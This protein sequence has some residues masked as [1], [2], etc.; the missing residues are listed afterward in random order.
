MSAFFLYS[1]NM[2]TPLLFALSVF[3]AVASGISLQVWMGFLLLPFLL[4]RRW[5]VLLLLAGFLLGLWRVQVYE[6]QMIPAPVNAFVEISGEIVEEIDKRQDH[7]KITVLTEYGRVLVKLSQYKEFE[8]G[9][10]VELKG[11]LERPSDDIEGFDYAAY[12]ARYRVWLTMNRASVTVLEKAEP[13]IRGALYEFKGWMEN[14]L[15]VLYMEP[16]ASFAAGLLLG[17]RKGMPEELAMAFQ[18]V[19]LTHIVAISG[20][21][22]SLVIAGMFLF[23]SFLPLKQRVVVS[24][25]AII[26]FVILVGASAAVVRAGIMGGLTLWAL[27]SG[28]KSQVFFALLWSALIMVMMNPYILL[29]DAGFQLSFASTMG[30]L[31]FVPMLEKLMPRSEKM[32]VLREAFLLT[33]AA[34]IATVPLILLHFGRLSWISPIAN[35]L[36]APFLAPA[37]FFGALSLV[38]GQPM[39]MMAW[40]NLRAVELIAIWIS[41]LPWIDLPLSLSIGGFVFLNLILAWIS[42]RFY[43]HELVRA[44]F[45]GGEVK[46][47][48][49]PYL[50]WKKHE[51]Q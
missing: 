31:L 47:L 51:K 11:M 42:Y 5:K 23:F 17:S 1:V 19:G 20:Y 12:L 8:F 22:I 43:K 40:V 6:R 3:T 35:V 16:E 29:Y 30:L 18:R 4:T 2:I 44:F 38:F 28:R 50:V 49:A 37:M 9:D 24:T 10:T 32:N 39:A 33:M 41:A 48:L 14:R 26:L 13:S 21:N 46:F 45:R 36:A 25:V 34:Q 15:N 27:F 7:Q